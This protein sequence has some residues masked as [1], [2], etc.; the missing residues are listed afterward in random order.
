MDSSTNL[1][2]IAQDL[3]NDFDI[4][5]DDAPYGMIIMGMQ[6][7]I[8]LGKYERDEVMCRIESAWDR[9]EEASYNV[10]KN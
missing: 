3:S 2:K 1:L 6:I 8:A 5:V 9:L 4:P 10:T 7:L